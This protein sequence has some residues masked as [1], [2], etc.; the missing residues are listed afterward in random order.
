MISK[1]N[2]IVRLSLRFIAQLRKMPVA[3]PLAVCAF[4][5]LGLLCLIEGVRFLFNT[6]AVLKRIVISDNHAVEVFFPLGIVASVAFF[7]IFATCCRIVTRLIRSKP[8]KVGGECAVQEATVPQLSSF[9]DDPATKDSLSRDAFVETICRAITF[10][11]MDGGKSDCIA[12]YGRWG[13]G[14]TSVANFIKAELKKDKRCVFVDFNPWSY[15]ENEQLPVRLFA[16]ICEILEKHRLVDRHGITR[17]K[18]F[19]R[20]ITKAPTAGLLSRLPWLKE[21]RLRA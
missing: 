11:M 17:M 13:D 2:I 12:I 4:V 20:A 14:K 10:R 16:A 1:M 19:A 7:V 8:K 6:I 3:R 5:Y 15:D 9:R 18:S 21:M